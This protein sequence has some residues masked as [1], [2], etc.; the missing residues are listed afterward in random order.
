MG[1]T[2]RATVQIHVSVAERAGLR[3]TWGKDSA[4]RPCVFSTARA[5]RFGVTLAPLGGAGGRSA[6]PQFEI[7]A[8][9]EGACSSNPDLREA[10]AA[11]RNDGSPG[12]RLLILAPQ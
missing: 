10:L 11:L 2:S 1:P 3:M 12:P 9:A 5:R 8:A 4:A 7:T 6:R